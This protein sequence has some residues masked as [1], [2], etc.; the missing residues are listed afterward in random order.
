MRARS[1]WP[2]QRLVAS[3]TRVA[4]GGG[5]RDGLFGYGGSWLVAL[6]RL[7]TDRQVFSRGT[8]SENNDGENTKEK[9][10]KDCLF[11]RSKIV[12]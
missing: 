1:T 2:A 8:A 5:G 11:H 10:K 4:G 12:G 6:N 9:S 7:G 3:P